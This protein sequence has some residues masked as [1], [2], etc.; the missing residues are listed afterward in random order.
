MTLEE[1]GSPEA[2]PSEK[3]SL[4]SFQVWSGTNAAARAHTAVAPSA[5]AESRKARRLK[6]GISDHNTATRFTTMPKPPRRRDHL[7]RSG[8]LRWPGYS[9]IHAL[10]WRRRVRRASPT[11][12]TD[13]ERRHSS[14]R[15]DIRVAKRSTLVA[16][17]A[18]AWAASFLGLA[19][20]ARP[21]ASLLDLG[22]FELRLFLLLIYRVSVLSSLRLPKL[23]FG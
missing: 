17:A 4:R 19:A 18:P 3:R 2:T 8:I 9:G 14:I 13:F 5:L 10:A 22:Y 20:Q 23:R 16:L 6:S 1:S 7:R 21:R 11:R 12:L 15:C